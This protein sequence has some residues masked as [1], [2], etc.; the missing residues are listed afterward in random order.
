MSLGLERGCRLALACR[1]ALALATAC[2]VG[3]CGQ[4][5]GAPGGESPWFEPVADCEN[6]ARRLRTSYSA[7]VDAM[8]A[9]LLELDCRNEPAW[10]PLPAGSHLYDPWQPP[11]GERVLRDRAV[12]MPSSR[13]FGARF[14]MAMPVAD[15]AV[16]AHGQD[17]IVLRVDAAGQVALEQVLDIEG[18]PLDARLDAQ[19]LAVLSSIESFRIS[20][21]PLYSL[22]TYTKLS[23]M[24]W[25]ETGAGPGRELYFRGRADGVEGDPGRLR[26][27]LD[28]LSGA[29]PVP[30][31]WPSIPN[32]QPPAR[33]PGSVEHEQAVLSWR[34]QASEAIAALEVDRWLPDRYEQTATGPERTPASCGDVMLPPT[35]LDPYTRPLSVVWVEGF[36]EGPAIRTTTVARSGRGTSLAGD[37]VVIDAPDPPAWDWQLAAAHRTTV[38]AALDISMPEAVPLGAAR[39]IGRS[40]ASFFESTWRADALLW[41]AVDDGRLF[42]GGSKL[43]LATLDFS[44]KRARLTSSRPLEVNEQ[45]DRIGMLGE[46]GWLSDDVTKQAQVLDL[47][48]IDVPSVLGTIPAPTHAYRVDERRLLA[49]GSAGAP[50]PAVAIRLYDVSGP[51]LLVGEHL[52][53]RPG[54]YVETV[55]RVDPFVFDRGRGLFFYPYVEK[56]TWN[57][58]TPPDARHAMRVE[59]FRVDSDLVHLGTIDHTGDAPPDCIELTWKCERPLG[60]ETVLLWEDYVLSKSAYA[61]RVHALADLASPVAVLPLPQPTEQY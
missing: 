17:L 12:G 22:G 56:P 15:R 26:L 28:D 53:G 37:R 23:L 16:M 38:L 40:Q 59:V 49:L 8:Q 18:K 13:P 51:P 36:P 3:G 27:V 46:V 61:V 32:N 45:Q 20:D 24:T 58:A 4:T 33:V 47:A 50:H 30:Q 19:S 29:L 2:W 48:A 11:C 43:V 55:T 35:P 21:D 57:S 39:L 44:Q 42:T 9:A 7:Y 34:T 31:F 25:S 6:L 5:E 10:T 60:I 52:I 54:Y 14:T 1:S 41:A